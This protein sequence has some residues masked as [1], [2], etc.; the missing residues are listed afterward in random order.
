MSPF[1]FC[2]CSE[3]YVIKARTICTRD[4]LDIT[5]VLDSS[6]TKD[7]V[8]QVRPAVKGLIQ[9]LIP[10]LDDSLRKSRVACVLFN[11]VAHEVWSF[12][13]Y[14]TKSELFNAV[15][16]LHVEDTE[17]RVTGDALHLVL[18]KLHPQNKPKVRHVVIIITNGDQI[19]GEHD[20]L[21]EAERIKAVG[22]PI[23]VI[24]M[25]SSTEK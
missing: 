3:E 25:D 18:N 21:I 14:K 15:D 9:S 20:W 11:S 4:P 16:D 24:D 23:F 22:I 2:V 1:V 10:G 12:D 6:T 7:F 13:K 17:T 5:F 8:R 19:G